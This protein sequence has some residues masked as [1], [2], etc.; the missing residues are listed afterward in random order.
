[1]DA[2]RIVAV[3]ATQ[4]V[5]HDGFY[6]HL[7]GLGIAHACDESEGEQA[8]DLFGVV[9]GDRLGDRLCCIRHGVAPGAGGRESKASCTQCPACCTRNMEYYTLITDLWTLTGC[10]GSRRIKGIR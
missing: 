3:R 9:L 5:I 4:R 6:A 2:A 8:K 10:C 7:A 1:M